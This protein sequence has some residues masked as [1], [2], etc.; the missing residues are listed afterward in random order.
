MQ[1]AGRAGRAEPGVCL[2]LWDE[3]EILAARAR[4]EILEADLA[5]LLLD[6][7]SWGT[8]PEELAWLT[9]PPAAALARA[10]RTLELLGAIRFAGPGTDRPTLTPHG[11]ALARLPLHPRLGHMLLKAGEHAALAAAVAAVASERYPLRGH[12]AT[13]DSRPRLDCLRSGAHARLRRSAEQIYAAAGCRAPFRPPER[14][15]EEQTGRLIRVGLARTSGSAPGQGQFPSGVGTRGRNPGRRSSGRRALAGRGR[16]GR[17]H[18]SGVSGRPSATG[19]HRTRS[20]RTADAGRHG[21]LGRTRASRAGPPPHAAG[22]PDSGR[23]PPAPERR[24]GRSRAGR[25]AGGRARTGP[26]M[27][28]LDR[29]TASVAGPRP[30]VARAGAGTRL[31]RR[32]RRR[33]ARYPDGLAGSL[34]GRRDPPRPIRRTRPGVRPGRPA[35]LSSATPPDG[36]RLPPA[37]RCLRAHRRP[38]TIGPKADRCWPSNCRKCSGRPIRPAWPEAG[39]RSPCTCFL[40]PGVRS[41]SRAI[42]PGSGAPVTLPCGPKCGAAIPAIPGPT[43][44]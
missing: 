23:R 42:W 11:E 13:A 10:R 5:P 3:G 21:R 7:L 4:P 20:R 27:P 22:R 15:D 28:A 44:R 36:F 19:R 2:R 43:T 32:F 9:P 12:A 17:R 34:A 39:R 8:R 31:A 33:S 18:G 6:A 25:R 24:P 41:K 29:G 30:S 1:R 14:A 38:W 35:P 16:S 40:R 26:A 37:C